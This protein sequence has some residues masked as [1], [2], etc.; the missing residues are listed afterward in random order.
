MYKVELLAGARDRPNDQTMAEC[1]V[2]TALE[3]RGMG[4]HAFFGR[5]SGET[6]RVCPGFPALKADE[7]GRRVFDL[8]QRHAQAI[9]A[10]LEDAVQEHRAELVNRSL[11]P[12]SV[13]MITVSPVGAPTLAPADRH[14]DAIETWVDEA[15]AESSY[16]DGGADDV[17]KGNEITD[18][19]SVAVAG[20]ERAAIKALG[21]HLKSN[22]ELKRAD[23]AEWCHAAG[24]TLTKRGFQNRVW[25]RARADAGLESKAAPGR[26]RKSSR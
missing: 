25:P 14:A 1:C 9:G 22:I 6:V 2:R 7:I 8:H 24:F 20:D 11:P 3:L 15:E 19:V 23:A 13:L 18:S 26:K 10:V 5:F 21:L 17:A 16:A 12:S 4:E